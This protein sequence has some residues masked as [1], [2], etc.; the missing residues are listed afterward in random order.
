VYQAVNRIEES[1]SQAGAELPKITKSHH[2][3]GLPKL[4]KVCQKRRLP[5]RGQN[6]TEKCMALKEM[7]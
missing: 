3:E 7:G 4:A 6:I 5:G 1:K 2:F